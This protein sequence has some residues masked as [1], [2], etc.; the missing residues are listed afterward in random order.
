MQINSNTA[1]A[2]TSYNYTINTGGVNQDKQIKSIQKQIENV[3][4]QLQSLSDNKDM[5]PKEMMEKRK[6][7]Q[8]QIQN[9]NNQLSQR[10]MEIQQEKLVVTKV[11]KQ[12]IS[13]SSTTKDD[14]ATIETGT[15]QGL[16]S[17]DASLKQVNSVQ[18]TKTSMEGK[19]KVLKIEIEIDKERGG[20]TERKEAELAELNDRINTT[21]TDIMDRI[22]NIN[23]E[24]EKSVEPNDAPD[25]IESKQEED[26]SEDITNTE[27]NEVSQSDVSEQQS[28]SY[29]KPVIYTKTGAASQQEPEIKISLLV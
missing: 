10:K 29:D 8:Q 19:A 26:I 15:M 12:E 14:Y 21:S 3:Q 5:S 20:S 9:L 25:G 18:S 7:L 16:I 13:Q 2:S 17:A 24:L 4:N 28:S 1:S 11:E 22:S 23:T 6:E 27:K